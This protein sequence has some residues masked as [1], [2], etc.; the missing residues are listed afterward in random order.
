MRVDC[1]TLPKREFG[2]L[3]HIT[4][5]PGIGAQGGPGPDAYRFIEFLGRCGAAVW[6]VLPL[7]PT[8]ACGSPYNG[9]SIHAGNHRLICVQQLFE[10]GL[11]SGTVYRAYA[12]KERAARADP[13]LHLQVLRHA[14]QDYRRLSSVRSEDSDGFYAENESWLP[15]YALYR[16]LREVNGES[17]WY[18][19][20]EPL[21]TREPDALARARDRHRRQIEFVEFQQYLFW[22]Q[23]RQ[24]KRHANAH[25]IRIMGDIPIFPA[26]DSAEVWCFPHYFQLDEDGSAVNVAGVPPDYFSA[27]GQRW[28][29]PLYNWQRM[30]DD[31][32]EWWLQRIRLQLGRFDLL[33]LDHFRGFESYW[34]IPAGNEDAKRGSW[35][36]A[37]GNELFEALQLSHRYLPLI[38]EDLGQITPAVDRLRRRFKL[39]GMRVLQFAFDGDA[40]NPHLPHNHEEFGAVYTGTHDNPTTVGWFEG[41]D[42]R[43]QERV[44]GYLGMPQE[45][46]PW[47]LIR[48]AMSSVSRLALLPL[49][50]VMGLDDG[51]R[52]NIPGTGAGNWSW[53]FDWPDLTD[54]AEHRLRHLASVY[55]R[56]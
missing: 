10:D 4:S 53:R 28:G 33:R 44:Y 12:E 9:E 13:K 19:W 41:L 46:M 21:R 45:A 6:Q 15:D 17:P 47:A 18:Q 29:N 1:A 23:W 49:Q 11:V 38:A 5:L 55:G 32:F 39:P 36:S 3:L 54:E 40:N 22:R 30:Q 24:L 50:D 42:A 56:M 14:F 35:Q 51:A 16:V 52:M 26:Y 8:H 7:V 48:T 37:P 43:E 31:G 27:S 34:S 20:P 25:D 2:I